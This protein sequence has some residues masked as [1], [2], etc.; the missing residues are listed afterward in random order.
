[1]RSEHMRLD[2]CWRLPREERTVANISVE[3]VM[4]DP[5][6]ELSPHKEMIAQTIATWRLTAYV[7]RQTNKYLK[8]T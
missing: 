8:C 5:I 1:M 7:I 2:I 6:N 4:R 3:N